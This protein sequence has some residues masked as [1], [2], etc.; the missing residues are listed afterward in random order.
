VATQR[1]INIS[2]K[3]KTSSVSKIDSKRC[4][5]TQTKQ[6]FDKVL[7]SYINSGFLVVPLAAIDL[8]QLDRYELPRDML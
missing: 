4:K 3:S 7:S 6:K 5:Q 1:L 2:I 8:E